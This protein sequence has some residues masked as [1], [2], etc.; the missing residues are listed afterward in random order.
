MDDC[1]LKLVQIPVQVDHID[2]NDFR[3]RSV[4]WDSRD[5]N[6]DS[7]KC[8]TLD[9]GIRVFPDDLNAVS[10]F[11]CDLHFDQLAH[12]LAAA[13]NDGH[14]LFTDGLFAVSLD[15][16]RQMQCDVADLVFG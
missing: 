10:K 5:D 13:A 12:G 11:P 15:S 3:S 8:A 9:L 6:I 7:G 1:I 16:P 2:E 14:L 4:E